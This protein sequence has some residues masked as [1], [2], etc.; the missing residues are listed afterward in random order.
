MTKELK[1][2]LL[3]LSGYEQLFNGGEPPDEKT[4]KEAQEL[5][6]E[7]YEQLKL[8]RVVDELSI[9]ASARV[10]KFTHFQDPANVSFDAEAVIHDDD[11]VSLRMVNFH[12]WCDISDPAPVIESDSGETNRYH[13]EKLPN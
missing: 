8:E 7:V 4:I 10:L 13:R 11:A 12:G 5:R 3:K 1:N 2:K 9:L 6:K